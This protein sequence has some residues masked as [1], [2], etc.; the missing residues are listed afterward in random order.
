M[1]SLMTQIIGVRKKS[2][3]DEA[4][5]L[6]SS[7]LRAMKTYTNSGKW[8]SKLVNNLIDLITLINKLFRQIL[9]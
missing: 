8:Y 5:M 4:G 9:F 1:S 6:K 7:E 2:G 3:L